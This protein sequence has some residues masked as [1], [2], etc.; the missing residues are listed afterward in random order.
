MPE[1]KKEYE[2][3]IVKEIGAASEQAMGVT[4]CTAGP[5]FAPGDC[6]LGFTASTGCNAGFV[7]QGCAAGNTDVVSNCSWG[8]GNDAKCSRG[9]GV[10]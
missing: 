1:K 9:I 5:S 8:W 2:P 7:D 10:G 3:P 4:Q 6:N